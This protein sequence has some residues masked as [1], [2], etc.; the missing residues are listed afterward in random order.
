MSYIMLLVSPAVGSKH[1]GGAEVPGRCTLQLC[2]LIA[3]RAWCAPAVL[4]APQNAAPEEEGRFRLDIRKNF[5]SESGEHWD[6]MP[7]SGRITIPEGA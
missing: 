3:L 5:F 4:S 2:C 6:R 1:D 7:R